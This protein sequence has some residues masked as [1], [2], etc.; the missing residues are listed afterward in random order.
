MFYELPKPDPIALAERL[1]GSVSQALEAL[2]QRLPADYDAAQ[3]TALMKQVLSDFGLKM[4]QLAMALRL[5]LMGRTE[6]PSI[7]KVL[8][9][10][11]PDRV[12]TAVSRHIP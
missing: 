2:A 8:V 1:Q 3:A 12:R 4:P 5:V 11:G 7:D 9:L 6:T 10:L